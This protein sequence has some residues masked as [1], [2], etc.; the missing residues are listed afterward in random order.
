MN[1]RVNIYIFT[2]ICHI[3]F[4]PDLVQ[5]SRLSVKLIVGIIVIRKKKGRKKKHW[6]HNLL[7]VQ[8]QDRSLQPLAQQEAT[9]LSCSRS[10]ILPF[11]MTPL[12]LW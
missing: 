5:Q 9:P 11:Y 7:A 2:Q 8:E 1:T 10:A 3:Y 12:N 4:R 6:L